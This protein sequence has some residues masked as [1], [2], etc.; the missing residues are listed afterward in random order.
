MYVARMTFT[1][2]YMEESP[3]TGSELVL[4]ELHHTEASVSES[5]IIRVPQESIMLWPVCMSWYE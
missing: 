3:T 2:R 5:F 4:S 1:E